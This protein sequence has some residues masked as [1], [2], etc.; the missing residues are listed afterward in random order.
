MCLAFYVFR[1]SVA[2]PGC[3]SRIPDLTT[4]KDEGRKF[5]SYLFCSHKYH[6]IEN[7]FIFKRINIMLYTGHPIDAPVRPVK[8]S[9]VHKI[10]LTGPCAECVIL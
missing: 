10:L 4:T 2:D 6:K 8:I 1:D 5:L 7:Y 9:P 3:L